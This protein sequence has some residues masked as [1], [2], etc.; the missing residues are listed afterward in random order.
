MKNWFKNMMGLKAKLAIGFV[1]I[2]ISGLAF[3]SLLGLY[4]SVAEQH[5]KD[6]AQF[7]KSMAIAGSV[8]LSDGDSSD[9]KAFI[10]QCEADLNRSKDGK[11][12][13]YR[14]LVR[15][16]G[17]RQQT[18]KLRASTANHENIWNDQ[19]TENDDRIEIPLVEGKR[20]WGS[21]EIVFEPL[22][23]NSTYFAFAEPLLSFIPLDYRLVGFLLPFCAGSSLLF[24]YMLFRTPK[25][26]AAEGRVRQALGSLAEGLLVLDTDGRIKIA[27]SVFCEKVRAESGSLT[28]RRPENEFDWR[29]G[30]GNPM[31]V[32]PWHRAAREGVEVRDTVMTLQQ[33][34]DKDGKPEI[35]TFQVN[36][37]PVLAES[38]SGNGV[39]VCFEDVT[40]LQRSKKAAESANQAKSDFLANMSHEIRTPMNAILGFTDWLQ[41]GLADDRDQELEYLSTIH[42]SGTHLLELI[43]DVLDLSKI[44][45]GK[46]EMVL[47]DFSPFRIVQD[48]ERVLQVRAESKGI[49]L[50]SFFKGS[51]PEMVKTDYVR[52]RQVLTNLVGN[53]IKFTEQGGVSVVAEMVERVVDG[54]LVEKLR[55]EVRDT[56]IGMTQEQADKIFMPFV[57]ADSGITRQFGGTGLGLSIS[58]RIVSALGGEITVDSQIGTGSMFAFEI[59]VGD[60]TDVNR[61]DVQDYNSKISGGRNQLP[62]EFKLPPGRVLVVDDGKPN[63]QLIRLILTKAGCVVDE[64]ENGAEG[65]EM[66]LANDYSVVL[67]DIQMPVMDGFEATS[68]LRRK[69]YKKTI[70][71]LTANAMREDQNK[72]MTVGFD[73]FLAKPVNIDK[74]I[75]TLAQWMPAEDKLPSEDGGSLL[76]GKVALETG[77][78]NPGAMPHYIQDPVVIDEPE[79]QTAQSDAKAEPPTNSQADP[80][81]ELLLT[82]LASICSVAEVGNWSALAD[83]LS[84]LETVAGS[85]GR[86]AIV[87]SI[88]PLEELCRRDEHDV[89]LIRHSL[90]NF[91]TIT[92]TF[93]NQKQTVVSAEP[94]SVPREAV[95]MEL[96]EVNIQVPDPAI[97]FVPADPAERQFEQTIDLNQLQSDESN[98]LEAKPIPAVVQ[99]S[100]ARGSKTSRASF[101]AILQQGLIDLQ[102]AWDA[103]DSLNAIN[104]AQRLKDEC[105]QAGKAVVSSSLDGLIKAV[106][107]ENEEEYATS[108]QEFL[109][110]CRSE[111]TSSSHA[112]FKER[113]TLR[114]LTNLEDALDPIF[115]DLPMDDES[116]REIARDFVPQLETKLRELDEAVGRS[117]FEEI[118]SLAHWLKGA[119]GT[120]GFSQFTEPSG[121]LE[122]HA[123]DRDVD[124]CEKQVDLL[125]YMGSQIVIEPSETVA[126]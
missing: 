35:A 51:L 55:I 42:S 115:S 26:S 112:T 16:I 126:S 20:T 86:M 79:Q 105:D 59:G 46:M 93:R 116:F 41:R 23:S 121:R 66:A 100:P 2:L 38:S 83:E 123:N 17:V 54:A 84:G 60:L 69:G 27:S 47:E 53:A 31:T 30:A 114:P 75:E 57:Q 77:S 45:A 56:G 44:E 90:S 40:E 65:V 87:E 73:A 28:N 78:T 3:A 64:A 103:D 50:Q 62:G 67:M 99:Q 12:D 102:N 74:L 80:F 29:D 113:Q 104:V 19:A 6:R 49:E 61:I 63:R 106:I 22:R 70:I 124:R 125:W 5:Q 111:F 122:L 15:S 48:V 89:D 85:H 88:R 11:G 98:E 97:D 118:A 10:Q 33:G 82:S 39:L 72:C 13:D 76:D 14:H 36:C 7:G 37:S 24:L 107:A 96:P 109:D 94:I 58:K 117:D 110:A 9:L 18:G 43:N 34:V 68:G 52:L 71:A 91:L 4:P 108:I 120:C 25:N 101:S 81:E 21:V 1:A 119:G 95:K 32:Y 92:K 8:M